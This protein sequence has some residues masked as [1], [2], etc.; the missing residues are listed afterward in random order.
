MA[1]ALSW[2][3]EKVPVSPSGGTVLPVPYKNFAGTAVQTDL[4]HRAA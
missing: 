2:L 3:P 1:Q 4:G